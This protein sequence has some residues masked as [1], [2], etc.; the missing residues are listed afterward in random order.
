MAK[1]EHEEEYFAVIDIDEERIKAIAKQVHAQQ[2]ESK[3][4][5]RKRE[6]YEEVL[7]ALLHSLRQGIRSGAF[8]VFIGSCGVGAKG[9]T[10]D[11]AHVVQGR[12]EQLGIAA[13]TLSKRKKIKKKE[14]KGKLSDW[15]DRSLLSKKTATISA[16]AQEIAAKYFSLFDE[17]ADE[18]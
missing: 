2:E 1:E 14:E 5:L 4:K 16:L 3:D 9:L 15:W 11:D 10:R 8:T 17:E 7:Y 13:A 12:C 6:V 18:E